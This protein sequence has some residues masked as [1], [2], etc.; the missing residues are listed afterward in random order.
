MAPWPFHDLHGFKD[1]ISFVYI[2]APDR[3][4][5]REGYG[6]DEQWTLELAFEGLRHGLDITAKEKGELPVLEKCRAMVE[7]AYVHYREGR[8][9]EGS[10]MLQDMAKLIRKLRSQ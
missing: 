5:E 3:F 4:R 7:E 9:R 6:P 8:M 1:Y 2:R 10:F